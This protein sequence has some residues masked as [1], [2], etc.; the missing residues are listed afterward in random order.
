MGKSL[1]GKELGK[2]ITQR[3]SGK[4]QARY[5]DRYKVRHTISHSDLKE[6]KRALEKARYEAEYGLLT[7][8]SRITLDAW[9]EE[10]LRLY[11]VG[12]VKETT[13]YRIRQTFSPCKKNILGS[14]YLSDIRA[15][16]VQELINKLHE[17]GFA[18]STLDLLKALLKE[19]FK[20][21]IGNGLM[22]INP[23]EAVVLPK[24]E[25]YE[26]RYLTEQEQEIFLDVAKGH[27]HYDIFCFA[28]SCGARIGEILGLKWSDIDFENKTIQI[29]RTLHYAKVSDEESCHFFFTT[30]KT[31]TSERKIPMLPETEEILRRV[32][33]AQL[34][35]KILYAKKWKQEDPFEDM[36]FTTMQGA[37]IRYGDV[38]RTIKTVIAKVNLQEEEL[39]KF[40]EREPVEMLP[41]SPHCF[42]HTFITRCKE[43]GIPYEVIQPYVGHST[44]EMTE[45]YNHYKEEMDATMLKTI[46][47]GVVR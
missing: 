39:A 35:N 30:P 19:L 3:E 27:Y 11:K 29:A 17:E 24:R 37:P 41:F 2:G 43:K 38:N 9:F 1:D 12:K 23:C 8:A 21:A 45:Y 5:V 28:L 47:F 13:V 31:K 22:I 36:V 44:K 4:Y 26:A 25:I 14:M 6:L 10:F 7:G 15:M 33:R 40:E 16:H 18:Y 20:R 46:N 42:R 34:L 32:H